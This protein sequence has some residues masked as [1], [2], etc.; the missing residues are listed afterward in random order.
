MTMT[1]QY[2]AY[3]RAKATEIHSDF[4]SAFGATD[5]W[6][7][8]NKT[9]FVRYD[10]PV[11]KQKMIQ[12]LQEINEILSN[13]SPA[14]PKADNHNCKKWFKPVFAFVKA[15]TNNFEKGWSANYFAEDTKTNNKLHTMFC[16]LHYALN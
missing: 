8:R 16:R 11:D 2:K 4:V 15:D 6:W 7:W 3:N 9:V 12:A 5:N 14:F 1:L 13:P 10:N